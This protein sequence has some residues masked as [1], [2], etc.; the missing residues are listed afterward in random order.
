MRLQGLPA[1]IDAWTRCLILGS[2]PG[3]R[4]LATQQCYGH[5]TN[6]FW[7]LLSC[8][9]A[10]PLVHLPYR[11]RLA[12]LA[13]RGVGLWDV[14]RTCTRQG[15]LDA[16]IRKAECND[17]M[18]LRQLAPRLQVVL[19]NGALAARQQGAV[20]AAGYRLAVLPSSSAAYA[21]C[22]FDRKL[23]AWRSAIRQ[24]VGP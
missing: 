1:V 10:E 24:W 18:R 5:P 22:C 23:A 20:A 11:D 9:L 6:Q 21:G 2:F 16:A 14:V 15:S 4:S 17:V 13:D 3:E 12:R 8:A 19:F 7:P